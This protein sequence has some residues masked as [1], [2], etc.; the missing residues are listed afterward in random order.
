MSD[1]KV[2]MLQTELDECFRQ[3]RNARSQHLNNMMN[4][5]VMIQEGSEDEALAYLQ[6][7]IGD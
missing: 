6:E 7:L 5:M 4:L 2:A 1:M 3:A